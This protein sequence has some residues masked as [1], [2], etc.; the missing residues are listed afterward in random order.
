LQVVASIYIYGCDE[1][2]I[3]EYGIL[4]NLVEQIE[5]ETVSE[6]EVDLEQVSGADVNRAPVKVDD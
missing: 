3:L 2:I 1:V 5:A 6:A 4:G